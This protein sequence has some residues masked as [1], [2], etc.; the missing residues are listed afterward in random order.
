[1]AKETVQSTITQGDQAG[2]VIQ[3]IEAWAPLIPGYLDHEM[4]GE[5]QFTWVFKGDF[6]FVERVIKMQ[7]D[8]TEWSAEGAL[9]TLTGLNENF[10]GEGFIKQ[11]GDTLVVHLDI[12]AKGMMGAMINPVLNSYVPKTTQAFAEALVGAIEQG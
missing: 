4:T 1:M 9:F 12:S 8:L 2:V 6:G 5:Q 7:V 3:S 11:E 10:A